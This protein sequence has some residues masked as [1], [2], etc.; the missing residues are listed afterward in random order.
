MGWEK[1]NRFLEK[2]ELSME[3][4]L[5]YGVIILMVL[6][7]V[8]AISSY[9]AG[10]LKSYGPF[11]GIFDNVLWATVTVGLL[12]LWRELRQLRR[13]LEGMHVEKA[14]AFEDAMRLIRKRKKRR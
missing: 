8:T 6:G 1:V 14:D 2:F 10:E 12:L 11:Q 7:I 4:G 13:R 9:A 5:R 3:F